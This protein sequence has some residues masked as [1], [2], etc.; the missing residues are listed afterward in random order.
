[1][2]RAIDKERGGVGRL[3]E[4]DAA[5]L[6]AYGA[7]AYGGDVFDVVASVLATCFLLFGLRSHSLRTYVEVRDVCVSLSS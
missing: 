6:R 4:R 5:R 1:M 2:G 3:A 7:H